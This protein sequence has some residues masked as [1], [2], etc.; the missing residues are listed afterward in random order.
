MSV[1]P[2]TSER[3][4]V[5]VMPSMQAGAPSRRPGGFFRIAT[6]WYSP[7]TGRSKPIAAKSGRLQGPVAARTTGAATSPRSVST[8]VTRPS[9]TQK[10]V[11][12]VCDR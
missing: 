9:S 11:T 8:P 2:P 3:K 10:P 4:Y 5:V 1:R 7:S 12:R 6:S